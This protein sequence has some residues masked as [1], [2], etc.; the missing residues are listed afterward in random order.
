[1]RTVT[2]NE[3]QQRTVE[4]LTRLVSGR[5]SPGSAADL[6]GV[7]ERHVRRL[8]V[9][10]EQE[11]ESGGVASVVH[12]NAGRA[13][14]HKTAASVTEQVVSLAGEGGPYFGFS[15]CHLHDLLSERH[16]IQIGRSTLDRL[17]KEQGVN[18]S[19][20]ARRQSRR[21]VRRERQP[22]EGMLVQIDG[23]PHVWLEG[24]G[25]R[26]CLVGAIDDATGKVLHLRFHPTET[27]EAYL[28]LLRSVAQQYGL[29]LAYY[30]DRHTILRSPKKASIEDELAGREP[31][32]QVQQ[33]LHELGVESIAA[34]SPQA[35][36]RVERLW[37][38]LQ[39]RLVKEMRLEQI[40]TAEAA[41]AFLPCFIV[42]VMI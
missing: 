42:I 8:R 14:R 30:H 20:K 19:R 36:G 10:F 35:K 41:N 25:P 39:D 31:M 24:R 9:R 26:L 2:L 27:Q 34:L 40:A 3:E 5:L 6:L 1:M 11:G 38:T 13:H 32:S 12:G 28:L 33:V 37:G 23:S 4:V 21:F 16:E 17:L 15:V 18:K 7:S 29:P 22:S